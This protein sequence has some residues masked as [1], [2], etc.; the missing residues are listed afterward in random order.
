MPGLYH[1]DALLLRELRHCHSYLLEVF[2][3]FVGIDAKRCRNIL[4]T[5]YLADGRNRYMLKD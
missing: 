2:L 5:K 4:M 1:Q 3:Q